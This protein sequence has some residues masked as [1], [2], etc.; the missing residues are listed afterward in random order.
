MR[1]GILVTV[2]G[3]FITATVSE[4]LNH[5]LKIN[6]LPVQKTRGDLIILEKVCIF[7]KMYL[8]AVVSS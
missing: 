8:T 4:S 6:G 1:S 2:C 5:H 7:T 3:S